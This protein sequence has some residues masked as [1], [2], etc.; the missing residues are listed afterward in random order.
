MPDRMGDDGTM[1][2]ELKRP[3]GGHGLAYTDVL[4][5]DDDLRILRGHHG[6]VFVCARVLAGENAGALQHIAK[7]GS[8]EGTNGPAGSGAVAMKGSAFQV[9]V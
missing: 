4:F 3:I 7:D 6:Q 5:L 1:I 8:V 9:T 2:Y